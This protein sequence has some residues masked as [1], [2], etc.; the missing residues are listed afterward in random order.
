MSFKKSPIW[1]SGPQIVSYQIRQNVFN[2]KS[3]LKESSQVH[4]LVYLLFSRV[5]QTYLRQIWFQKLKIIKWNR[6]NKPYALHI[7]IHYKLRSIF[8]I[9]FAFIHSIMALNSCLRL[10]NEEAKKKCKSKKRLAVYSATKGIGYC[11]TIIIHY[12]TR[13]HERIESYKNVGT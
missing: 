9:V 13:R 12:T 8:E 7:Q 2:L 1:I 4:F 5:D 10:R 11:D 6:T 3:T